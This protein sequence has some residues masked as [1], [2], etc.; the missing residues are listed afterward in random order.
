MGT[1][2]PIHPA[3]RVRAA[4]ASGDPELS[5]WAVARL[6]T[7]DPEALW[8]EAAALLPRLE[9][10]ARDELV[11]AAAE[12]GRKEL[13]DAFLPFA[14]PEDPC[15]AAVRALVRLGHPRAA[16]EAEA[17]LRA[18]RREEGDD[19]LTVVVAL[20][21]SGDPAARAAA[22]V[23]RDDS[24]SPPVVRLLAGASIAAAPGAAADSADGDALADLWLRF[25]PALAEDERLLPLLAGELGLAAV[26]DLWH[27][28]GGRVRETLDLLRRATDAAVDVALPADALRDL[29][30]HWGKRHWQEVAATLRKATRAEAL[31]PGLRALSDA[32][33]ARAG[34]LGSLPPES[35][36]DLLL[37]LLGAALVSHGPAAAALTA[38][39]AGQVLEEVALPRYRL[40]RRVFEALADRAAGLGPEAT[41]RLA[42]LAEG[43]EPAAA[44]LALAALVRSADPARLPVLARAVAAVGRDRSLRTRL[45]DALMKAGPAALPLLREAL[46]AGPG[47]PRVPTDAVVALVLGAPY[48]ETVDLVLPHVPAWL[49]RDKART[50]LLAT[51][52]GSPRLVPPLR[53]DWLPGE[54]DVGMALRFLHQLAGDEKAAA[55]F[56]PAEEA[57]P[58]VLLGPGGEP[59]P[60]PLRL[61]LRCLACGHAYRY[62]VGQVFLEGREVGFVEEDGPPGPPP[63]IR[64]PQPI[65]C[66]RCSA[67]QNWRFTAEAFEAL[68]ARAQE[69]Q[70]LAALEGL[71]ARAAAARGA[72]GEAVPGASALP[73][74]LPDLGRPPLPGGERRTEGGLIIP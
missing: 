25:A 19:A 34:R 38:L 16:G 68:L 26:A 12:A 49:A 39:P 59:L 15:A 36:E 72:R 47:S 11:A 73:G 23:F 52:L 32:L 56:A 8:A 31:P 5:G 14:R 1:P 61:L 57:R 62:E 18:R 28:T 60:P 4:L 45:L 74:G 17:W 7:S 20:A 64:I 54:R 50:L 44:R 9:H 42:A 71:R 2:V 43:E 10:A 3:E 27:A 48:E 29:L 65:R 46:A 37:L 55:E 30:H 53:D 70:L 58:R 51:S 24:R 40:D 67:E 13:G 35:A 69:E 33:A 6:R 63:G 66:R 22:R 41:P 21:H